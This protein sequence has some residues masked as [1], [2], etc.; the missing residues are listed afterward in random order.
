M[1]TNGLCP[2]CSGWM[3]KQGQ[4]WIC[5]ECGYTIEWCHHTII[6]GFAWNVAILLNGATIQSS[7]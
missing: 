4:T 1:S 5:V 6:L 3:I 2:D 7:G